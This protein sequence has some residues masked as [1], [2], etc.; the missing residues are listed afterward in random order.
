MKQGF[1]AVGRGVVRYRWLVVTAWFVF[2]LVG[3]IFAPRIE[4]V[5]DRGVDSGNTGES[6]QAA[7]IIA[8][9]FS[10]RSAFQQLLVFSSE[11]VTVE[12][13]E[14]RQAAEDLIGSIEDTG[15][16]A[17]VM[18]FFS[19]GDPALVSEDGGTTFAVLDLRQTNHG[20]AMLASADIL[21]AVEN[22]PTPTWLTASLTGIE[23]VHADISTASQESVAQAELVG[24]PVAMLVLIGV[25]G[26]LGAATLPLLLAILSIVVALALAVVVG[27]WRGLSVYLETFAV[28]LGMGVGIDYALFMLT[29]FRNE[30]K[31]GRDVETAVVEMVTHS[32][33]AIAFSGL[34]VVIG[35][36]AL[37][38]TAEPTVI[39][40]GIG[41]ILVVLVAVAAGLTLLPATI[42]L[43]GDRIEAPR[44]LTR[45]L[46]R[47]REGGMWHRWATH[48]MRR[49]LRY[50][51]VGLLVLGVLALPALRLEKG[52][53]GVSQLS[54]GYQSRVGF[55]TLA[56]EFGAGM[57]SPVEVVIRTDGT[58]GDAEIVAGVDRLTR[59]IA[60]DQRFEEAMSMTTLSPDLSLSDYQALYA[61][62]FSSLPLELAAPLG[63]FVNLDGDADTTVIMGH[64]AID[65]SS[66]EAWDTVAA[67][68]NEIIPTVSEL[69][70]VEVLVGGTS[71]I[72]A[73]AS[74]ALYGRFPLVIGIILGATFL[75]LMILFRSILIPL[76]AVIMNLLSVLAAYGL[77]VIVFQEGLG[78]TVFDF[79]STGTVNWVTPV[80]LFAILF[81]LSMD[82]E[83]FL[84]SRI[85]ELHERG[86][87]NDQAVAIGLE[88][89]A[90][91][92]T[93]AAA[94]M[95]VVFGSFLLSSILLMKEL[96]FALAAAVLIDATIVRIILVPA[97]MRLLG[98]WNWWL[99]KW[100]DRILPRVSLERDTHE[101]NEE[102]KRESVSVT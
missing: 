81:G 16:I 22:A 35:L 65:P 96:G 86:Y 49:P 74:N 80:L 75:M 6:Q 100:L 87:S 69:R 12:D 90:K 97:T 34:A 3:A 15:H 93:G 52:T 79:T 48:V 30:R 73:D 92:I 32:G 55:E 58:V 63:N 101:L 13:A 64:L 83:V 21:D 20:D 98:E 8:S 82:Y 54:E 37:L 39:S 45:F 44:T 1:A 89:T 42:V 71:A 33:K 78:E 29:R 91:V 27:E 36:S 77:L 84:L 66:P 61:D 9:E 47:S 7:D 14:Y 38:A 102:P 67:V 88:N 50:T 25:F 4:G 17:G 40:M 53:M 94:I 24:L 19:S 10:S 18:S 99:P 5:F 59:A 41:G 28:M 26:A 68:R 11:E 76:K 70:N 95:V 46:S 62:G 60:A 56:E 85:R 23:A 51:I 2:V 43:L 31:G 57:F 72:E